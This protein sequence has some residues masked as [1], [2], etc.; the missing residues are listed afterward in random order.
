MVFAKL[1]DDCKLACFCSVRACVVNMV[2]LDVCLHVL[3]VNGERSPD[4]LAWSAPSAISLGGLGGGFEV[5]IE[6]TDFVIV[7][8]SQSA[9]DSFKKGSN[10]TMGGNLTVALGPVGRNLEA[11]VS[12]RSAAAFYTY[13]RSR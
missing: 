4:P 10:V 5:G 2:Y 1:L 13:S 3:L 11:D 9:V 12:L 8:N 7:L 6:L